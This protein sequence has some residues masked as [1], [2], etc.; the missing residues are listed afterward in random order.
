MRGKQGEMSSK[1][2]KCQLDAVWL[3]WQA[4]T[5]PDSRLETTCRRLNYSQQG[6]DQ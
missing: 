6:I 4:I 2:G 5:H 1:R 3:W